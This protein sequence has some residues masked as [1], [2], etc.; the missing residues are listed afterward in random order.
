MKINKVTAT[1]GKLEGESL[2]FHSGLNVIHAPN[3]SGKSTWCAFIQAM[4]YGVDSSERARSGYLPD[5]QRY[6]PWSGAPM[7][8]SMELT[9][10][11]KDITIV[12]SSH[13]KN[14]PMREFSAC[15]T[16]SAVPVEGL[17]GQNAGEVLTGVSRD[18]F[19]RSAFIAQ[20]NLSVS[21]SPDLEK[22]INAI[23]STGE[24]QNSYTEADEQ[25]RAWQRRRRYNRHGLLPELESRMD[26]V[27]QKLQQ[28]E[29]SARE[30]EQ[31][32]E[33]LA[34]VRRDCA[35][36][37]S[38]VTESRKYQRKIALDKLS[39]GRSRLKSSSEEHDAAMAALSLRREE[40]RRSPFGERPYEEVESQV[41]QDLKSLSAREKPG[42][43]WIFLL[44]AILCFAL[45]ALFAALYVPRRAL[46]MIALAA[47]F[48]VAAIL[49]FG[50]FAKARNRVQDARENGADILKKYRASEPGDLVEALKQH[51]ELWDRVQEAQQAERLCRNA[52]E[53][54]QALQQELESSA[55]S[56]LDF[57]EGSSEAVTLSRE[58]SARRSEAQRIS[59]RLSELGGILSVT[60]DPMV[61]ASELKCMEEEY[62]TICQESEA[63]ALA[64]QVLREAD[65]EMQS[66][67]SP[68][69]GKQAAE[70]MS[71][72]TGGRYEDVLIR[73]DFTALAKTKEDTVARNA[74][75]L[76]AGTLDLMYLAVR[77]AV[78]ELALPE[79]E[80]CPLIID[81][82]LVNLDEERSAKALELLKRIAKKRQVILFSC[83]KLV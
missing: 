41:E 80:S 18:V 78:C 37:E 16:G 72:L 51:G 65:G 26:E 36:L 22:R 30:V 83:K 21:G 55:M 2:S 63:I 70:Y 69:L 4:L 27:Q 75:Y 56:E 48:C 15:Y 31:L 54:A 59:Q 3:E 64:A 32:E 17:N 9:A 74:E 29:D 13:A 35:A 10:E 25:L 6:A 28:L 76:S 43:S 82:A 49:C 61:L 45:S 68:R 14:A 60:G 40:L 79:G 57:N 19:R 7:E 12:R 50:A 47:V 42:K 1:F 58:L 39:T 81:D 52:Y 73:R 77:L 11:K 71:Q 66:R 46:W 67:F 53:Q 62:E 20:G 24:E 44:P 38:Q 5:K 23:V 33:R 8:G 34:A